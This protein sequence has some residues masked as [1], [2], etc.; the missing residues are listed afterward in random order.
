MFLFFRDIS[1]KS[2]GTG[3]TSGLVAVSGTSLLILQAA[4]NGQ[5]NTQIMLSWLFATFFFSGIFSIWYP[6]YKKIPL[7]GGHSLAG[8]SYLMTITHI[9]SFND[10][11]GGFIISGLIIFIIG[12]SK[13]YSIIIEFIPAELISAM[14]AGMILH[15]LSKLII[16]AS[17]TLFLSSIAIFV[18]FIFNK[19]RFGIPPILISLISVFLFYFGLYDDPP[20]KYF[21]D[22]S[23][24]YFYKP[25][26]SL[27][28]LL[29][30]ALPLSILIITNDLFI[31]SAALKE[32]GY[33]FDNNEVVSISGITS[34]I[35]GFWGS[36]CT[37]LAGIMTHI[38]AND[39]SGEYKKRY[40]ASIVSGLFLVTFAFTSYYSVPF[41][42][43][44]PDGLLAITTILTLGGIF[45]NSLKIA[46]LKK[47]SEPITFFVFTMSLLNFQVFFINSPIIGLIMGT[48]LL[49]FGFKYSNFK[50]K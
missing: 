5:Y 42:L 3:I 14:L 9:Y 28:T 39:Q 17:Q 21:N 48:V 20:L 6:L 30:I 27:E 50:K 19:N 34:F 40:T 43:S 23:Y 15:N 26:F 29:V 35:G 33:K 32:H 49:K 38:C 25:I 2:V 18:F 10:L 16:P 12:V 24:F 44:L 31:G 1:L 41:L 47:G 22:I 11:V 4:I 46:F 36:H 13:K 37:N 45:F 7:T 8:I